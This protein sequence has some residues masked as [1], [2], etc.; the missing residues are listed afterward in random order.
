MKTKKRKKPYHHGS[1]KEAL[2]DA[3]LKLLANDPYQDIGIRDLANAVGVS[4]AAA[5]RHFKSK[6][7]LMNHVANDGFRLLREE[8]NNALL[9]Q[10]KRKDPLGIIGEC[11]VDFAHKHSDYFHVMFFST[12][13]KVELAAGETGD[14]DLAFAVLSQTIEQTPSQI[15]KNLFTLMSWALVHG[16]AVL[17]NQGYVQSNDSHAVIHAFI[18]KIKDKP[19]MKG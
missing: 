18:D 17:G 15:D 14:R 12:S 16:L 2:K 9:D 10:A 7:D 6:S 4:H 19:K 8:M 13:P 11:Y 3:F 5:Y 1:L